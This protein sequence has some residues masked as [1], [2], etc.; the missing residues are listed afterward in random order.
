MLYMNI[1][2][3]DYVENIIRLYYCNDG[4]NY[5]GDVEIAG[6]G[7]KE[8]CMKVCDFLYDEYKLL[9]EQSDEY[10]RKLEANDGHEEYFKKTYLPA[11]LLYIEKLYELMDGNELFYEEFE[12][13]KYCRVKVV[14]G[15]CLLGNRVLLIG[16]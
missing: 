15:M 9:I 1:T 14:K 16:N 7:D 2:K 10:V 11:R 3:E 5:C 12:L 4:V 13:V 6:V 8:L